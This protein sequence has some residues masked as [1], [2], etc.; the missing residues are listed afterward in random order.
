MTRTQIEASAKL[1]IVLLIIAFC[2]AVYRIML[3]VGVLS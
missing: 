2:Y 1:F 3:Q